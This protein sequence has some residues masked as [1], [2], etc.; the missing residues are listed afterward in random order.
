[1][2][3]LLSLPPNLVDCFHDIK[4]VSKEEF[5]CTSDPID[6][7]L[8]S[9][10]GTT[11]LLSACKEDE[12]PTSTISEWLSREKRILL[13]AGGQS[14]RLPSYA[15]SSK[16]LVPVP[17]FRW[18]R[19]QSFDQDLLDLQ[20]PLYE[21]IL[22]KA[23]NSMHTLIASGDAYICADKLQEIPDVDVVCYGVWVDDDLAKDHGVFVSSRETPNRLNYMLQKPT[24]DVLAKLA[25]NNLY[26][27]DLGVWLLSDRAVEVLMQKSMRDGECCF[28]D[29]Y[30]TFGCCLGDN[31]TIVD[32]EIKSLS[33]AIL[34]LDG[35]EFY[36]FGTSP[37]IISSTLSL[38]NKV[39]DQREIFLRTPKPHPSI[40]QQNTIVKPA[41]TA[42]NYETWIENSYIGENWTLTNRNIIT[43][44]PK[45][46]WTIT[47]S[48]G[49]CVDIAPY[50]ETQYIL[51]PYGFNDPFRGSLASESTQ[52]LGSSITEWLSQRWLNSTDIEGNEDL[53]SAKIFPISDSIDEMEVMLHWMIEKPKSIEGRELWMKAQK[54]SADDIASYA[55]LHRLQAQRVELSIDSLKA[56][57]KNHHNSIFYYIDLNHAAAK[58]V[59]L[60]IELPDS[61]PESEPTLKRITHYMFCAQVRRLRG[62][63]YSAD[64]DM[65]FALLRKEAIKNARL[66]RQNP[67]PS[68]YSD[69]IVWGRSP[70]RIEL[71]GGWSDT[72]P[73]CYTDGGNVLNIAIELNGQQ[74]LQTY[75]KP[76]EEFKIILR[77][78][79]LGAVEEVTTYESLLEYNKIGSPFSIPKAALSLAGFAPDF[80]TQS[81]ATLEEQL[82]AFGS[83]IEVS[84]LSAIPAGSGLG[85][86]SILATTVLASIADFC[87]LGWDNSEI[88]RRTLILEQLL[89]SGGGWQ[90][91]YGGSLQGVKLLQTEPGYNQNALV[92]WLP[93]TIFT[94]VEY[95]PCHLLYYTG[96][97]RTAKN[98]L[99]EV[100]R[101]CV[102]NSAYYL[103]MIN[104]F[105]DHA[106]AMQDAIQRGDFKA[107]GALVAKTWEYKQMIN[108]D[109][110]VETVSSIINLI[111][112]YCLGYFL[113]GAGGGG[114][115]YM[116]AKDAEAA[117][118]IKTI[119]MKNQPNPR[120]RFVDMSISKTGL[121]VSRS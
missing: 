98:I 1:M 89:T 110:N 33:V 104:E 45:N 57:A 18:S 20:L 116:V 55:N 68:V 46:N 114:Y 31:P 91:Q 115:L 109:T 93:D 121:Q 7:K 28:Y 13:H 100:V 75:I 34:P 90:D 108:A 106:L 78:I 88:C 65:A 84:L 5:F 77:S 21:K 25:S 61:L 15:A 2:K 8:G 35:G 59:E 29:L 6:S 12:D 22:K 111:K 14:R 69:Q 17:V 3:K 86:S 71:A 58:F 95:A 94:S 9:G 56:I 112:D 80:S 81:Y 62:E 107:Y 76:C 85:T 97:T 27:M 16:A 50:G 66:E 38:Q 47:I 49:I 74:P 54:F 105:K 40:F 83:G 67:Q 26:S 11:W 82:R 113:P 19:G 103:N 79:D 36:H 119:L 72:P 10:G 63:E 64:E 53:Q 51:R 87:T 42:D 43:G 48:E 60:G 73:F 4:K 92:R 30:S 70:V 44:I 39:C 52:F 117:A 32:D 99:K 96:I 120:A 37:E 102:L 24:L 41:L 23:P 101:G 118:K